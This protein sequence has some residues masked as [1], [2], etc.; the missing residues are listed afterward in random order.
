MAYDRVNAKVVLHGGTGSA[1][2]LG[3][4]W[5][6]SGE[7]WTRTLTAPQRARH[8]MT[9]DEASGVII[10]FGG[11]DGSALVETT[12]AY[13]PTGWAAYTN[14]GN[15][16]GRE[17]PVLLYEAYFLAPHIQL[18]KDSGGS[19]SATEWAFSSSRW[20][21]VQVPSQSHPPTTWNGA[22]AY[23]RDRAEL[24]YHG[25]QNAQG[26]QSALLVEDATNLWSD[27]LISSPEQ[28]P[29]LHGHAMVYDEAR[30]NFVLFGG[31]GPGGLSSATWLSMD[32]SGWNRS[33]ATG[34]SPRHG[35][36]MVWDASRQVVVLFGGQL[37]TGMSNE[38]WTWDGIAWTKVGP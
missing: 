1:T 32:G 34:P 15:P 5:E 7:C 3:D 12:V 9:F 17:Y 27:L 11:F 22:A 14:P 31:N 6:W 21:P 28:P 26:T 24:V 20:R 19:A 38:T 23:N 37:Q 25:G 18:G 30:H 16:G 8:A 4:A 33:A 2:L 35:H 29:A 13:S 36:R 10:M